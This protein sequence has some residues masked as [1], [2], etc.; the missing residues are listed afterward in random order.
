MEN[1]SLKLKKGERE[2]WRW[3]MFRSRDKIPALARNVG[4]E[5]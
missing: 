1:D 3:Q 5:I 4:R 2:G